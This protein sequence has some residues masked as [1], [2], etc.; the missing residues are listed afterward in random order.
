MATFHRFLD[1]PIAIRI[2]IYETVLKEERH[3]RSHA[4]RPKPSEG[5]WEPLPYPNL[6]SEDPRR[7][8]CQ[9][10]DQQYVG[11]CYATVRSRTKF[12]L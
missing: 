9:R 10:P 8:F 3:G 2:R 11:Y 7:A 6:N 5:V 4:R 1:L 12:T